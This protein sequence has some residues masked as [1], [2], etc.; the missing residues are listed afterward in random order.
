MNDTDV[1]AGAGPGDRR[2]AR[3][4]T[5][6]SGDPG[7]SDTPF[8]EL[9]PRAETLNPITRWSPAGRRIAAQARATARFWAWWQARGRVDTAAALADGEPER[10]FARM[11]KRVTAIHPNL[12]WEF[13]AGRTS[14]HVLVLTCE[15]HPQLRA[16]ASRWLRAAPPADEVWSYSN[17]RL[18]VADPATSVLTLGGA[19]IDVPSVAV[20]AEVGRTHVDVTMY[21]PGF[22]AVPAEQ[23]QL[24]TFLLLD[25]VLGEAAVDSWVGDVAVATDP[26]ADVLPLVDL[27]HVVHD[28]EERLT[29]ADGGRPWLLS[30]R[31][32][33]EGDPL[34][35]NAQ[36][37]LRPAS[38]PH[39]DTHIAIALVFSEWTKEGLPASSSLK[40]LRSFQDDLARRLGAGGRVVAHETES[41]VRTLH[42]YVDSTTSAA[43]QVRLAVDGW[44]DGSATVTE[45]PDPAWEGVRHL[46]D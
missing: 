27:P 19:Q 1:K 45:K 21:H 7:R 20:S 37:P 36:V 6:A 30:R 2:E 42:V 15:G 24:T 17:F 5:P 44:D 40:R 38:A 32:S 34:L 39:L 23:H 3:D 11:A 16:I 31:T 22:A 9:L 12:V 10:M 18:P 46:R 13:A 8:V 14:E 33:E 4:A 28:L 26:P 25:T 43:K 41:G 35:V 29:D